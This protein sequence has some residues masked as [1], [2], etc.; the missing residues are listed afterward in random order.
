ML[1]VFDCNCEGGTTSLTATETMVY[2]ANL[3]DGRI[4]VSTVDKYS[5][6]F[7]EFVCSK[8]GADVKEYKY[9]LDIIVND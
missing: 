4:E 2:D 8:C 3:V 9:D 5:D 1:K 7:M 6:G